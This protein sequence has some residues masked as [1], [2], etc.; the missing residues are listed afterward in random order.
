MRLPWL[1][2]G[3]LTLLRWVVAAWTPLSPDEAYYWTWSHALAPGYFDHPPMVAL[4]IR[5]GTLVAGES[6]LG[7]RLLA[8]ISAAAGTWLLW[9]TAEDLFPGRGAGL[10]AGVLLNAT[11]LLGAGAVTMTPDTPLLFFWTATLAVLVRVGRHP[12]WWLAVGA[13]SGCAVASKYTGGLLGVGIVL[14][15]AWVPMLRRWFLSPW[16]YAGG[17]WALAMTAPLVAWNE[18]HDW[19]SFAKQGARVG[20]WDPSAALGHLGELVAGQVGLATPIVF[21]LFVWAVA[22]AVRL[23]VRQ[24]PAWSLLVAMTVPGAAL[25]IQHATGDRVQAN[26]P[27]IIYPACALAAAAFGGRWWRP[28]AA[29]GFGITALVYVQVTL[30]PFPLPRRLDPTLSRLAGWDGVAAQLA[31]LPADFVAAES[32]GTAALLAWWLPGPVLGVEPRWRLVTLPPAPPGRSGF[33]LLSERR[34]EPPDPAYWT[35]IQPV[36]RV[37]RSRDGVEA[38]A[39]RLYRVTLLPGAPAVVLPQGPHAA[40]HTR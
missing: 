6:A 17:A 21:G 14:W 7:V 15:L 35:D 34:S 38:E 5:I 24:D 1:A 18:E 9:R 3:G 11:L 29:I 37:L 25:F 26:W 19:A 22:R 4:W 39:Y 33:L 16:L 2:L 28:G 12:A 27:A 23:G 32:Y 8:P 13:L 10:R 36:G 31:P 40:S 30:A 20:K